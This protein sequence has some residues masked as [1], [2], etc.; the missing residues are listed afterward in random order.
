MKPDASRH[1]PDPAY[2]RG[3]RDQ[4]GKSQQDLAELLAISRRMVQYYEAEH[5]EGELKKKEHYAPYLYQYAL[6]M[7]A[8]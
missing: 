3:L 2:L 8:K 6:E 4:A 5:K 7:L 1:N